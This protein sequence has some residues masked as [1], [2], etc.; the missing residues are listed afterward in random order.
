METLYL[1]GLRNWCY[2]KVAGKKNPG[3]VSDFNKTS[4]GFSRDF[5]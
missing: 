1:S 2:A 4:R 5:L 3:E